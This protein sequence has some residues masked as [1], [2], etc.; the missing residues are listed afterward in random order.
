MRT[1]RSASLFLCLSFLVSV[2]AAAQQTLTQRPFTVKDEIGLAHFGDPY[3][4][5][6]DRPILVSP[7]GKMAA[8]HTERGLVKENRLEDEVR[9]YKLEALQRSVNEPDQSV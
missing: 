2:S 6:L 4:G 9:I 3:T 8:V 1:P 5:Q 7:D